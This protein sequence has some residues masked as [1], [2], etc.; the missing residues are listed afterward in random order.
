MNMKKSYI[1]GGLVL[2]LSL[3]SCMV[4]INNKSIRGSGRSLVADGNLQTETQPLD[5]FSQIRLVGSPDVRFV[6]SE[7]EPYMEVTAS[8][9]ILP[10]LKGV[11]EDG[12]LTIRFETPDSVSSLSTGKVDITVYAPV[13]EGVA[14][15]GSG[16]FSTLS[17]S[18]PEDF[19]SSLTGSGDITV[20]GLSC[21]NLTVAVAG[22]GDITVSGECRGDVLASVAGSG[23]VRVSGTAVN[24]ALSV[25]GSGDIDARGLKVTGSVRS[26]TKGSGDIRY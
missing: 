17:L 7:V 2:L 15:S 6:Q 9:N 19:S 22:S 24:A 10:Y 21:R 26:D 12:M 8:A 11:V 4:R 20:S 13:L 18:C 23:D 1:L 3:S 14:V 16:E 5:S 25:A